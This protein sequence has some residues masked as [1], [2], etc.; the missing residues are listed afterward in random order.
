LTGELV[1]EC[2]GDGVSE[3]EGGDLVEIGAGV[4]LSSDKVTEGRW[5]VTA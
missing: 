4:A 3:C 1:A 5:G 2:G